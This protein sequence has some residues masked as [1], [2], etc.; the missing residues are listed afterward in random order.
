MNRDQ[1]QAL[2]TVLA[3][4]GS[5]VG[6]YVITQDQVAAHTVSFPTTTPTPTVTASASGTPSASPSASAS[7]TAASPVTKQGA[8]FTER[9]YGGRVQLSV[10]KLNGAI[11]AIAL[12]TATATDGRQGAFPYLV[13]EAIAANGSNIANV[14]GATYSADVFKQALD[15]ALSKF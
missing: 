10:T 7:Q 9:R 4:G 15:S 3:V 13:Q 6:G 12:D 5:L 8:V 1:V 14:S 2:M 11:T